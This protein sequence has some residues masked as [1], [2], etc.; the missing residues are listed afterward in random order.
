MTATAPAASMSK[1]PNIR[2]VAAHTLPVNNIFI[3]TA[4]PCSNPA[5]TAAP[6]AAAAVAAAGH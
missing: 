5:I 3:P 1:V 4:I 2:T 6:A